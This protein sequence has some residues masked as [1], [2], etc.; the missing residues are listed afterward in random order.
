MNAGS[1]IYTI[2][3]GDQSLVA[4][5]SSR[6]YPEA[7]PENVVSPFVVY[8]VQSVDPIRVKNSTSTIEHE[9]TTSKIG[10]ESLWDGGREA[11]F[12]QQKR[13]QSLERLKCRY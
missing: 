7:A 8:S 4:L 11:I 13:R 12:I 6:I 3:T 1:A 5:V 2:L 9:A 10:E